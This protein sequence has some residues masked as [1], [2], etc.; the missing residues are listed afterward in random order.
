[1]LLKESTS[2]FSS[3]ISNK[4]YLLFLFFYSFLLL[5][6]CSSFSPL[7][8]FNI[9][10]DVNVYYTI[11]KGLFFDKVPYK[12]L[13][14]H[15]GPII[16]FIYAVGYIISPNSFLG[17]YI[18]ESIFLFVSLS[19]IY[20]ISKLFLNSLCSLCVTFIF[21]V[22]LFP[23]IGFGGSA[24][25]F[26]LPF[27]FISLYYVIYYFKSDTLKYNPKI[28]FLIGVLLAIT[29]YIKLN[30]IVFWFFPLLA[31]LIILIQ[32]RLYKN[33]I[34]NSL[35]LLFGF[36]LVTFCIV[37]YFY[38]NKALYDFVEAY[39]I[40][41][42]K[43]SSLSSFSIH[44]LLLRIYTIFGNLFCSSLFVIIG[45]AYFSFSKILAKKI[46][47][48]SLL[49]TFLFLLLVLYTSQAVILY[50]YMILLVFAP[51]GLI[52]LFYNVDKYLAVSN[53]RLKIIA[54]ILMLGS[55][56]MSVKEK[57]FFY[58]TFN[59]L[60]SRSNPDS[61]MRFIFSKVISQSDNKTL[62]C[63]GF[64]YHIDIFTLADIVPNVRHFFTPNI[65]YEYYPA[66][67]DTQISY[68]EDNL[69]KF[70]IIKDDYEYKNMFE[71]S[72]KESNYTIKLHSD[73]FTLYELN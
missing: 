69:T 37:I 7:Y 70:V 65:L 21:P 72:L 47:R 8:F 24:E 57:K 2:F 17:M 9:W 20:F 14:D 58:Y 29:F 44:T 40:L 48:I 28:M 54:T 30:I 56:L 16:F 18:I 64:N 63:V 55:F 32:N 68:I 53:N 34:I 71:R 39:F 36:L 43:Y 35:S 67:F 10:P 23:Y 13:F 4:K 19:S 11:G 60:Y 15:K 33:L 26:I 22:M 46:G 50:Y 6:F 59:S 42:S 49:L 38:L 61:G 66:L 41:N 51:L 5:F 62:L 45:V 12:D 1:M 25:E 52:A 3:L 73:G 31:I 27:L